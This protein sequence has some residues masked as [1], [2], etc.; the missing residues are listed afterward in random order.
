MQSLEN[1]LQVFTEPE[2]TID[3]ASATG[4]PAINCPQRP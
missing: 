1:W 4:D 2:M 3:V